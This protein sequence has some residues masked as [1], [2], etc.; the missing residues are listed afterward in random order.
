MSLR[1]VEYSRMRPQPV[2]VRLQV[3][4]GSSC[5]TIAN[6]GVRRTL[7]LMMCRAIFAVSASGNRIYRYLLRATVISD[8]FAT[9]D[10]GM[11][12]ADG[13]TWMRPGKRNVAGETSIERLIPLHPPHSHAAHASISAGAIRLQSVFTRATIRKV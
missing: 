8:S 9:N 6:F 13:S 7:C 1:L 11:D 2:Q 3:C 12:G 4:N 5:R 10:S